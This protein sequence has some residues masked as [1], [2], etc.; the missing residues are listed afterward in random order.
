[1]KITKLSQYKGTTMLLETD[2]G[3]KLYIGEKTAEKMNLCVGMELPDS[4]LSAIGEEDIERK[5]RERAMYLLAERD[6]GFAEL[7][8]KLQKNYPDE[9]CLR[10]CRLMAEKGFVNDRDYAFKLGRQYFEIKNESAIA[11]RYKLTQKGIPRYIIDEVIEEY[12]TDDAVKERICELI[13]K[14]YCRRLDDENGRQKVRAA[15][16]RHGFSY[17]DINAAMS[18]FFDE[19]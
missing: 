14:K 2:S 9:M 5:S 4:A 18:E 19:N 7:Y 10:T 3:N 8:H 16:A 17:S 13:Q 6:Y 15:L 1:M 12:C 11:V